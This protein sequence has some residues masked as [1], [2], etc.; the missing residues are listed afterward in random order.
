VIILN[1]D[2]VKKINVEKLLK[3]KIEVRRLLKYLSTVIAILI[4]VVLYKRGIVAPLFVNGEPV[5]FGEI[6]KVI[7]KENGS[8][9]DQLI[10]EKV[11]QFEASKRNIEVKKEEVEE[12]IFRIEKEALDNGI[13]LIQLLKERDSSIEELEKNTKTR[14]ML[15]KILSEDVEITEWEIEN[16]IR[17]NREFLKEGEEEIIRDEV[18]RILLDKKVSDMYDTWIREAKAQSEVKYLI[19]Y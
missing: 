8:Y 9:I 4:M 17:E 14:L 11:I 10:A 1:P 3:S 16:Y 13:T 18:I 6:A 7:S 12:E 5:T 15:Y 19:D 2:M